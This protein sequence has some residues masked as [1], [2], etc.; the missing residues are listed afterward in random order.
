MSKD[1][2]ENFV[3]GRTTFSIYDGEKK[4]DREKGRRS[5]IYL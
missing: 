3:C 4:G 1:V 5:E 2:S